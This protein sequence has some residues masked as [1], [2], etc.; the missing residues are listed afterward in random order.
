M[1]KEEVAEERKEKLAKQGVI[2]NEKDN[3]AWNATLP[4]I[5]LRGEIIPRFPS[6]TKISH[7]PCE[8]VKKEIATSMHQMGCHTAET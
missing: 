6:V 5:F 2:E 3:Y 4:I 7:L 8:C 1:F